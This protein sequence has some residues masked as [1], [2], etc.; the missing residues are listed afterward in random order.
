MRRGSLSIPIAC[1]FVVHLLTE[2]CSHH[3]HL[4][5][6]ATPCAG[7]AA[8]SASGAANCASNCGHQHGAGHSNCQGSH[9][10]FVRSRPRSEPVRRSD[11]VGLARFAPLFV[12]SAVRPTPIDAALH[13]CGGT[14]RHLVLQV[15][16]I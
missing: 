5:L 4:V 11:E 8:G 2:C 3:G 7:S 16:L 9:F 6:A 15:L 13:D 10:V 1:L 14:P 12:Q